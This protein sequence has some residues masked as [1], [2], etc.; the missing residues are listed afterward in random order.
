MC[1]ARG[2][3]DTLE[4]LLAFDAVVL[5]DVP[6]TELRPIQLE[7][8]KRYVGEFGGGLAMLGSENSFGLGGYYRSPIEEVLPLTS[9]FVLKKEALLAMA[10]VIDKSGSMNG[11]PIELARHASRAA[12]ELLG[13][14]D[15]IAVIGHDSNAVVVLEMTPASNRGM[16]A[17][18]IDSLQAG[19]GTNLFQV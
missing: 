9:R 15:Q 10:L 19:G 8:L 14:N 16:I 12:A 18:S 11:L 2:L 4:G 1:G 17:D 3:P 7:Y 6:A 13:D 5:A